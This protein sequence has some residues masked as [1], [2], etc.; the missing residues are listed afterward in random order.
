MT[1]K[2]PLSIRL[3]AQISQLP[4]LPIGAKLESGGVYL[5]IAAP[6]RGIFRALRGQTAGSRNR[7]VARRDM[8]PDRWHCLVETAATHSIEFRDDN[9]PR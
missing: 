9:L 5:D 6:G 3:P 2:R 1:D 8:P 7:Y 4:V